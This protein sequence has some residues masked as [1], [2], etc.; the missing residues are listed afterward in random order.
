MLDPNFKRFYKLNLM[1]SD[2]IEFILSE[3]HIQTVL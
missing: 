1:N 3:G 2:I